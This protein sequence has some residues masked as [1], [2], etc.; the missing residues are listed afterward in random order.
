[1]KSTTRRIGRKIVVDGLTYHWK[2]CVPRDD[3]AAFEANHEGTKALEIR[4]PK[5]YPGLGNRSQFWLEK[6][7]G[8]VTPGM[9][10]KII[11]EHR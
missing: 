10:A 3:V 9:V 6:D 4:G 11:R 1:M 7:A 2:V 8:A 5:E